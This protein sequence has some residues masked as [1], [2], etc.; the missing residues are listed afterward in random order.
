MRMRYHWRA[1][2]RLAHVYCDDKF[3]AVQC[4]REGENE[5]SAP[6]EDTGRKSSFEKCPITKQGWTQKQH[7]Q[8]NGLLSAIKDWN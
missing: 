1:S 3:F 6:E 8:P 5:T 4:V 7:E 2:T